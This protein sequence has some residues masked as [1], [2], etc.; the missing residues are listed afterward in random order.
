MGEEG[1]AIAEIKRM[2]K[3]EDVSAGGHVAE[4]KQ[5]TASSFDAD[6]IPPEDVAVRKAQFTGMSLLRKQRSILT[7]CVFRCSTEFSQNGGMQRYS[8]ERA[9]VGSYSILRGFPWIATHDF[10]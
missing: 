2:Q 8:L 10:Y 5:Q 6:E 9:C 7:Y 3:G 4:K 1:D